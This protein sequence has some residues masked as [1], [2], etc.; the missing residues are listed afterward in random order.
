MSPFDI[1][2]RLR[3]KTVLV[4]GASSGI[5][6]STAVLFAQ[7]GAKVI[8]SA[9]RAGRLAELRER[10]LAAYEEGTGVREDDAAVAIEADMTNK[11]DIETL[12]SKV[13]G[14]KIDILVNN[15]G[16][17]R[18]KE[19]VGGKI[20]YSPADDDINVMIQTNVIGLIRLT[21][22]V[23]REMKKQGSGTI[24]NLGS[25]AGREAYPGGSIYCATKHA[26]AAFSSSLMKEL[27][28]TPIRVCE[29]QP[30]EFLFTMDPTLNLA[31]LSS[32]MVET[33]FSVVRYRGD[34]AK[35]DNE[36]SGL[37][38]LV[39]DDIAEEIVWCASRPDHVQ[40]AQML[41]FPTAQASA[42]I[43]YRKPA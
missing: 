34:Q 38:P 15:A 33:E 36:Y 14:R 42:G 18:G 4:T 6:S 26:V 25:I 21:Q 12:V 31:D 24:I 13:N 2:S 9:R 3:D 23:V 20:P 32:G 10:C 16:M 17:V 28:N 40:V 35:A 22:L 8:L 5:G 11:I 1:T 30:G 41:V 37:K 39:A 19:H 43:S 29:I 7:C 27:V